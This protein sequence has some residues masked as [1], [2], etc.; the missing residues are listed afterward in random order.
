MNDHQT[1]GLVGLMLFASPAMPDTLLRIIGAVL[2]AA[3][4]LALWRRR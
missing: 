2:A 1:L 4:A 3:A